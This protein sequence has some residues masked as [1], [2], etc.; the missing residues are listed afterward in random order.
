M[1]QSVKR[2]SARH[3]ALQ[4]QLDSL[5]KELEEERAAQQLHYRTLMLNWV[6]A[7]GC[8]YGE[9]AA[10]AETQALWSA[11]LEAPPG[12]PNEPWG[13]WR[14]DAQRAGEMAGGVWLW[15][16]ACGRVIFK[17]HIYTM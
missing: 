3:G 4:E 6:F 7:P 5:A 13:R 2:G 17:F 16:C 10:R 11:Y 14:S 12:D 15:A 8:T 1:R 9:L